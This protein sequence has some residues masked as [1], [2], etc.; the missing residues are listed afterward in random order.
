MSHWYNRSFRKVHLLYVS[1][2]WAQNRGAKFDAEAYADAY[3]AAGVDLVQLYTKDH[4]GTCYFPCS[5]GLPYPRDIVGELLAAL[6]KRNIRMMAYVSMF[7]D[8]YAS[9]MHPD[10]RAVNEVGDP[11]KAGP[12]A[13]ISPCTPYTEFLLTQIE[14][15]AARYDVDGY[16]LDI[17]PLARNVP[18]E[19]WMIQ[20]QPV[21]DYSIWAQRRYREVTGE[22]LPRHPDPAA[23]NAIFE[24]MTA[25]VDSFM[26][27]AYAVIRKYR[28]ETVITYNA[29]GAPGDPLD[30]ADLI[31]IEGH[32]P[33]YA[34]QSFIARWAKGQ[35]KP[36]EMMTAG[37][38]SRTEYGG[39]WNAVDQKPSGLLELEAALVLAHGGN[40][41]VGQV[42]F[43]D[44]STDPAQ[45]STFAKVFP[46]IKALEPWL[47][48]AIG[49]S[50]VGVVLASKP[51]SASAHWLR[52]KDGAEATHQAL[53]DEHLQ[54][55]IIRLKDD[56]LSRYRAIVLADQTALSDTECEAIRAYVRQGGTLIAA[57]AASRFDQH[58]SQRPDFALGDVFGVSHRGPMNVDFAYLRLDE[59]GL[60]AAVT[61]VP[62]LI[63]RPPEIVELQGAR[64]L[65]HLLEPESLRTDATTVLWGDAHPDGAR[66]H[67]GLTENRFGDGVCYYLA[68]APKTNGLPNTWIKL[69]LRKLVRRAVKRPLVKTNAPVGVEVTLNR[70]DGRLGLHLVNHHAGDPE[71]LS[72]WDAPLT[73][74]G[75]E[76]ELDFELAGLPN[77]QAVT[78]APANRSISSVLQEGRL[79]FTVPD[80]AISIVIAIA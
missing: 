47:T 78:V 48:D 40:P 42:P 61:A 53:I 41:V 7:F 33:H 34:R 12:F 46:P 77:G 73:L 52:M 20:P 10:W 21:P 38:L 69:L 22:N 74:R 17:I 55:D 19:L 3:A 4:H 37:G 2:Q 68:F 44:G 24:F 14:E 43:P 71:R 9:G 29:A 35:P 30:S 54:Y 63:D 67:P 66:A 6:K 15:L 70:Q 64:T 26:E 49:V 16:W 5:L 80:F 59:E 56:D 18:Q 50:E 23:A 79:V 72:Y 51:R 27:R 58:G 11:H 62:I 57:G 8:N 1:P 39:G 75:I 76:V 60:Q 32:A 36:F 25:E 45:F 65:A 13:Y 31:S 28:P